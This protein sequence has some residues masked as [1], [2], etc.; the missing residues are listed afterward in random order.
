MPYIQLE[1]EQGLTADQRKKLNE[2][3]IEVVHQS[4]G[5]SKPH[6][7]VTIHELPSANIAEMGVAGRNLP[8]KE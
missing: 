5:A 8:G 4:M 6:I 1:I 7:C 2:D 3:V